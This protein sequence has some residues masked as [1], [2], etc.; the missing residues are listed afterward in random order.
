M[1][2]WKFANVAQTVEHRTCNS[3]VVGSTPAIGFYAV[4]A[5]LMRLE[6]I[7]ER[8]RDSV[9]TAPLMKTKKQKDKFDL[10]IKVTHT[11]DGIPTISFNKKKLMAL[12]LKDLFEAAARNIKPK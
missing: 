6:T 12:S 9:T 10:E 3:A 1:G 2:L 4:E 8:R 5:S 11:K 7:Q